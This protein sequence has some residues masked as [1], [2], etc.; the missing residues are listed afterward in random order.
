MPDGWEYNN[1]LDL[2]ID[3]S[4]LDPDNDGLNNLGEYQNGT[5][6]NVDDTDGDTWNDGE[7]VDRGTD[8]LDPNDYPLEIP[9]YMPIPLIS[10]V[11]F[12]VVLIIFRNIKRK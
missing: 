1:S 11:L 3:D 8:P 12:T 5:D 9:G 7:E 2:F 10:V 6:P 4:N